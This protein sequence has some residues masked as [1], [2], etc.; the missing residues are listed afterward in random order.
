MM[1]GAD[2]RALAFRKRFNLINQIMS[3]VMSN[4]A[5]VNRKIFWS[6]RAGLLTQACGLI[7]LDFLTGPTVQFPVFFVVPVIL[8]A[9]YHGAALAFRFALVFV[10]AR[11][12]CHWAWGFPMELFPAILN[13][14][15][16]GMV[17]AGLAYGTALIA[18][19]MNSLRI[20][21]N[22]LEARLPICPGC[23][24]VRDEAGTWLPL[25]ELPAPSVRPSCAACEERTHGPIF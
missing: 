16:R 25:A 14:L 8:A 9:W 1:K 24:L 10:L 6:S 21:V 12:A 11:F 13:N 18:V 23:G 15:M 5:S 7:A 17:L 19:R 20:R 2:S 4:P 22:Q 3:A